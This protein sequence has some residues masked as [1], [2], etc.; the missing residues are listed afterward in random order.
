M[1]PA[2]LNRRRRLL[3]VRAIAETLALAERARRADAC[4]GAQQL[5]GRLGAEAL[6]IAPV[7]GGTTGAA[8]AAQAALGGRIRAASHNVALRRSLLDADRML[9]EAAM[10]AARRD[11]HSAE[12]LVERGK[13]AVD[14]AQDRRFAVPHRQRSRPQ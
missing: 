12:L 14:T 3:R 9:A 7:V 10:Q 1:T 6:L 8:L 13:I 5:A 2:D 11:R 4:L